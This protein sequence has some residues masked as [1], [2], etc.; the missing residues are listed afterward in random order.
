MVQRT[1][2]HAGAMINEDHLKR[3]L[4]KTGTP[5]KVS[6]NKL[7]PR[8][9]HSPFG[10]FPATHMPG[11]GTKVTP[12]PATTA[13]ECSAARATLKKGSGMGGKSSS[14]TK[15]KEKAPV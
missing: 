7:L 1:T 13:A 15:P 6:D 10:D 11:K 14:L 2:N 3:I 9:Q 4:G 8:S 5:W 12:V